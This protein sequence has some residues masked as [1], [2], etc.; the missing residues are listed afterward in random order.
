MERMN[1]WMNGLKEKDGWKDKEQRK[2]GRGGVSRAFGKA[3]AQLSSLS[4]VTTCSSKRHLLEHHSA[5]YPGKD[6]F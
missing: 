3:S 1:G 4:A 6:K 2:G 5:A